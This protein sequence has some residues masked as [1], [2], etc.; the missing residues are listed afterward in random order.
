MRRTLL[1]VTAILVAGT[2][3]AE[4]HHAGRHRTFPVASRPR[5]CL[6]SSQG[7]V[8]GIPSR[9]ATVAIDSVATAFVWA[10]PHLTCNVSSSDVT[11]IVAVHLVEAGE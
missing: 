6:H 2:A 3:L 7:G 1:S 11:R 10:S 5:A 4:D 8:Y 9:K